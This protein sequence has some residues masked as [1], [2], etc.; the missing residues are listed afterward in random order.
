MTQQPGNLQTRC[1]ECGAPAVDGMTCWEQLGAILAWEAHDPELAAEH[2]L[3][4]ACY[5]LQHPAQFVDEVLAGLRSAL[6][7]RLD[8]NLPVAEIR[9]R[10]GRANAGSR[11]V[12][13]PVAERRPV[14]HQWGMSIADVYL[15]G[16]P[17]GAA[18]RIRAWAAAIR[19]EL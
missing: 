15:P 4:V 13:R 6:V 9:R 8:S 10:A 16:Q 11:R 12:L 1:A 3:T 19:R 17:A 14:L 5:N 18:T 7:E 2:F